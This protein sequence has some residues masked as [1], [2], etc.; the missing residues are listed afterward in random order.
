MREREIV[1]FRYRKG[2]RL[3]VVVELFSGRVRVSTDKE[4]SFAV[5]ADN[6]VFVTGELAPD[7]RA[8]VGFAQ[9]VGALGRDV[10]LEEVWELV[11]EEG[12][13]MSFRDLADLAWAEAVT[14]E[15]YVATLLHL[16]GDRCPY[17]HSD[18]DLYAPRSG[19][20]VQQ[21]RERLAKQAEQKADEDG[22]L[23]WIRG[24]G[25]E[26]GELSARQSSWLENIV[27]YVVHGDDFPRASWVRSFLATLKKGGDIRRFA[28]DLLVK[29]GVLKE[30]ENL[31]VR[32]LRVPVQF[33]AEEEAQATAYDPA[34]SANGIDRR[35]LRDLV[36]F[37]IDDESTTD[38][39]DAL[40]LTRDSNG[41]TVGV[42]ITDLTDAVGPQTALDFVA[43]ARI[44]SL[45]FPDA[46]IPMLPSSLSSG[47]ASLLP[48]EERPSLSL[49]ARLDEAFQLLDVELV[50][51]RIVN[52]HRL[53][54]NEVDAILDSGGHPLSDTLRSF[55]EISL[56]RLDQRR[57]SGAV[58]FER[59]DV[60]IRVDE[61]EVDVRV[62]PCGSVANRIV[63]EAMIF[64]NEQVA[65]FCSTRSVSVIYRT[66]GPPEGGVQLG[67]NP[68]WFD[69]Y[70]F[71]SQVSP[72]QNSLRDDP[73]ALLGLS[74]Y[75]QASSPIRRYADLIAQRQV[76]A[77]LVGDACYDEDDLK[78]VLAHVDERGRDLGRMQFSRKRYW[79]LKYLASRMTDS[80]EAYILDVRERDCL[81]ELVDY[82]VRGPALISSD[83]AA[84]A[85]VKV[86][87][88]HV[89]PWEERIRFREVAS[90]SDCDEDVAAE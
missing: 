31:A 9:R 18:G 19:N 61:G 75:C 41:Y 20:E 21:L 87:V 42:H 53:S 52:H 30:N 15:R 86:S 36:T 35:D 22:L 70:R 72:S 83:A 90:T 8:F 3:G 47:S 88:S 74:Q 23:A 16:A 80:F 82:G 38:I 59:P 68:T 1:A 24:E 60:E 55:S 67:E 4:K 11:H 40:S 62:K 73:H 89:D 57:R 39:D 69:S 79:L 56:A 85:V 84:G 71:F 2:L 66:Q 7:R 50:R 58:E 27:A 34:E 37:S 28:F 14:P 5:P 44:R 43:R 6:I 33:E 76:V 32:R 25:S 63:T 78:S 51:S 77:T 26:G 29:K 12:E 45:Y 49:L 65:K 10:N 13:S 46:R 64:Y 81:V 17:F 48:G 54:Y